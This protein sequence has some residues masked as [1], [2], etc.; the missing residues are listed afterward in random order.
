MVFKWTPAAD[1]SDL[2]GDVDI[3]TL[4]AN[5]FI[6][7]DATNSMYEV[8]DGTNTATVSA[9]FIKDQT[10]EVKIIAGTNLQI[11][12][13]GTA[14]TATSYDEAL[15]S[16]NITLKGDGAFMLQ[17]IHRPSKGSNWLTQ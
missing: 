17:N 12:V 2:S 4:G 13:D 3:I 7:Y 15:P 6:Y 10:Q 1:S 11:S 16:G 8:T 14:G 5:A 9:T